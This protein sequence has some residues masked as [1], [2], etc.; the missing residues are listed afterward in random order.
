MVDEELRAS[1]SRLLAEAPCVVILPAGCGKTHL[2]AASA[3][4]ASDLGKRVLILTHTHAGVDEIRRR[5]RGF[6]VPSNATKI[7]TIDSWSH[8]LVSSFPYSSS[9]ACAEEIVWSEVHEAMAR[10]LDNPHIQAMVRDSYDY[11]VVDEYQDCSLPQHAFVMAVADLVPT[12]IL[13]DPLQAIYGFGGPLVDWSTD[14]SVFPT[15]GMPIVPWRWRGHNEA[16]GDY[17]MEVRS[18]LEAGRALDA[19]AGPVTWVSDTPDHRRSVCWS[20]VGTAGDVVLLAQFQQQCEALARGLGGKFGV[21][22]D[23]DGSLLLDL[24]RTADGADGLKTA[25]AIVDFAFKS[26]SKLPSDLKAKGRAMR[27]GTFPTFR[28]SSS[29]GPVLTVL[30]TVETSPSPETIGSAF[31]AI[32]SLGGTLFRKEAWSDMVRAIR[33]WREGAT[34]LGEAVRTVRDRCRI[35]GRRRT[36]LSVSRPVLIKGQQFDECVVIGAD[37]LSTRELYVAMTRPRIS[38]TVMSRTPILNPS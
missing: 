6:D 31:A 24:A 25:A 1:A 12:V 20:K 32:D 30:K 38:L 15:F 7:A 8:R 37:D 5:A 35:V 29:I 18:N 23:V 28:P 13:G 26:H 4:A 11:V 3:R 10:L 19:S 34:T 2:V 16:L 36:R 27:T 21:M 14:L 33:V 17:L 9:Y 22:E